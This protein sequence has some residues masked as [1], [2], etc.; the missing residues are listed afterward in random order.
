MLDDKNTT[1]PIDPLSPDQ[2]IHLR[3]L[4]YIC[5]EEFFEE[6]Q[7]LSDYLIKRNM[8]EFPGVGFFSSKWT[9]GIAC[10]ENSANGV[11]G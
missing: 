6:S 2:S 4:Y 11:D 7:N 1:F 10:A 9:S 5:Y 3:L 8:I